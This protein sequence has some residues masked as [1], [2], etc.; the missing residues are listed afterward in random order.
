MSTKKTELLSEKL[1]SL[2]KTEGELRISSLENVFGNKSFA[3]SVVLLMALPAL[4]IPTGGISHIFEIVTM[5]ISLEIIA[6]LDKLWLPKRLLGLSISAGIKKRAL[7]FIT[8]RLK[9]VEK[10]TRP[11]GR[12]YF[13]QSW[14]RRAVGVPMLMLAMLAFFAPPFSGLDTLFAMGT[15]LIA[16]SLLM[17]DISLLI[18]GV[19]V[20]ISGG[21]VEVLF[22]KVLIHFFQGLLH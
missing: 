10:H 12:K 14:F 18:I 19:F 7:P 20:G 21:V 22:G 15:V 5:L 13:V 3:V 6:G 11:R 1:T 17:E 16:L 9:F 2:L 4:P 8:R